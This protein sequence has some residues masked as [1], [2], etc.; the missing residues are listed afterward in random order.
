M[1]FP[2][3]RY[4]RL[5]LALFF[6]L[7]NRLPELRYCGDRGRVQRVLAH[8]T[9]NGG[10]I[11]RVFNSAEINLEAVFGR[12]DVVAHVWTSI[13]RSKTGIAESGRMAL[14][15]TN[16]NVPAIIG[17]KDHGTVVRG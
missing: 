11:E 14:L 7:S 3:P 6:G 17:L 1:T 4:L 12:A 5:L 16:A 2:Y 9:P 13:L 15:S 8:V 10:G